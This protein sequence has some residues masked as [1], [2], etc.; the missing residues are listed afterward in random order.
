MGPL[1]ARVSMRLSAPRDIASLAVFRMMLGALLFV[2]TIRFMANGWV[3]RCF[4][5]PTFFFHYF[6]FSWVEPLPPSFMIAVHVALAVAALF[7]ALGLFYRFAAPALF[8]L[9]TYVELTD[10]TNYLNH[11]YLVSLLALIFCFLPLHG[12]YSLDA[13]RDPRVRRAEIPAWMLYLV[14]LQIGVVYFYAG[15]AKAGPDWLLHAQPLGIWLAARAE[16]PVVG[17][18]FALPEAAY[19]M[20]WAGFLYDTSIVWLLLHRRTRPF[21]YALVLFFH[22]FTH[23]LFTIGVFPFLMPMATTL[24]FEPNWPRR[25]AA[26]LERSGAFAWLVALRAKVA[27]WG[28]RRAGTGDARP[29]IRPIGRAGLAVLALYAALQVLVPL[30]THLYGG[31][32]L[33]HE[34]GMRWSWRV[35]VRE[36]DGAITYRVRA[37]GWPNERQVS[38]SRYL[39]SHQEREMSGQPD[40]ILRLA[41]HVRDELLARGE[42]DVEVRVDAFVSLN[43]RPPARM[44]DPEVDLARVEDSVMPVAYVTEMPDTPPL[45]VRRRSALASR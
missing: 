22:F 31:S 16:T 25:L 36:K 9:F 40:M 42:K 34:Q 4:E 32:V 26:T 7:V 45:A 6:G 37:R 30:R 43:G 39:T 35:M 38:P 3:A 12:A 27:A 21:A 19:V 23:V 13:L 1:F 2:S 5:R 33:W 15:L 24:F 8:V 20:S 11:Y 17:P 29:A 14:R 18:L 28:A 44:I 41:H 10:V